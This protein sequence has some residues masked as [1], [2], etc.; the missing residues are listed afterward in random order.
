MGRKPAFAVFH[1]NPSIFSNAMTRKWVIKNN[2]YFL[3]SP[4]KP[5]VSLALQ[6][7]ALTCVLKPRCEAKSSSW[8]TFVFY[9][10]KQE[11]TAADELKG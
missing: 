1:Q 8:M 11:L 2:T 10:N 5:I 9:G 6:Q 4:S 7:L 3:S